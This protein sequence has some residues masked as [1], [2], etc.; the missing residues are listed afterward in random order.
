MCFLCVVVLGTIVSNYVGTEISDVLKL[1]S[2]LLS[3]DRKL[4]FC[5]IKIN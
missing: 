3:I 1:S 4:K 2:L 5:S